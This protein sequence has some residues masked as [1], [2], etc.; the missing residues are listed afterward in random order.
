MPIWPPSAWFS[1]QSASAPVGAGPRLSSDR[2]IAASAAPGASKGFL[3]KLRQTF[4]WPGPT[5]AA[6]MPV[7]ED[8]QVERVHAGPAGIVMPAFLPF[9]ANNQT[10]ETAGMRRAY[11]LMIAVPE[12]KAAL[13]AKVLSAGS[14][15]L[16][17]MP[18]DKK[19]KRDHD[20]AEFVKWDLTRRVKGGF[21]G[22]AWS[23]LAHG[24]IDGYSVSEK[25]WG[26]EESGKHRGRWPL[27]GL[28]PKD[29]GNDVV[30]ELDSFNNI[31][32][33]MGLRYNAGLV[34][35]PADFVIFRHMPLYD[36]PTGMSDLRATYQTYWLLDT[37]WKIRGI[38]SE[39]RAVPFIWGTYQ[40]P[41]QQPTLDA[42]LKAIKSQNWASVPEGVLLQV[43]DIAGSADA[44][45]K[46]I[47]DDLAER[48]FLGIRGATLQSLTGGAQEQRGDS[49]VQERTSNDFDTAVVQALESVLNDADCGLVKDIVDLNFCVGEYPS[50]TLGG[51]D[52]G[53]IDRKAK[54]FQAAH[55]LGLDLSK[56]EIYDSLALTPPATPEDTLP[57]QSAGGTPGPGGP[58]APPGPGG[59][60]G[61]EAPLFGDDQPE[62][63]G[64]EEEPAPFD[65]DHWHEARDLDEQA[66]RFAEHDVTGESR[67]EAGKW[68]S[69]GSGSAK[70]NRG[71]AGEGMGRAGAA[72]KH[73]DRRLNRLHR[74]LRD[75]DVSPDEA[76][77]QAS[78]L[79]AGATGRIIRA[80]SHEWVSVRDGVFSDY[81]ED[82]PV[83]GALLANRREMLR[84]DLEIVRDAV[85]ERGSQVAD[86]APREDRDIARGG[87]DAALARIHDTLAAIPDYVAN[88]Y[89][90]TARAESVGE[91]YR[92]GKKLA[93]RL[94]DGRELT[95]ADQINLKSMQDTSRF[96][97][98]VITGSRVELH[99]PIMDSEGSY[100]TVNPDG[101]RQLTD[102]ETHEPTSPDKLKA[103]GSAAKHGE[104]A[105]PLA[106][107]FADLERFA[108]PRGVDK[109]F[110][111]PSGR[112]F[113]VK[114]RDGKK[115]TIPAR[116]P[117]APAKA[118]P[119]PRG[120]KPDAAAGG[121]VAP[122]AKSKPPKAATP[123]ADEAH[124]KI[125]AHVQA[126]SMSPDDVTALGAHIATMGQP[127]INAL[128]KRLGV[129]QGGKKD[130]QAKGIAEQVL[131]RLGSPASG[132][133]TPEQSAA[134]PSVSQGKIDR[135]LALA[136]R[137]RDLHT[138]AGQ[139]NGPPVEQLKQQTAEALQG[140]QKTA[141][142]QVATAIG[143]TPK[144]GLNAA[145]IAQAII[146]HVA[147][148]RGSLPRPTQPAQPL[149]EAATRPR[150]AGVSGQPSAVALP[151]P[152][153]QGGAGTSGKGFAG[154]EVQARQEDIQR[155]K[156]RLGQSGQK[157][158]GAR[159]PAVKA[160]PPPTPA[161]QPAPA[162]PAAAPPPA[163][164]KMPA[165]ALRE[166]AKKHG[167]EPG[168]MG[169]ADLLKAIKK[170][171]GGQP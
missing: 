22:L 119:K 142:L 139:A 127:E 68:T 88:N 47:T 12:I 115:R 169:R 90:A 75:G 111:G 95:E 136:N 48:V 112:W 118:A 32:G 19:N 61:E 79:T 81:G 130:L 21:P 42:V 144:A 148:K 14:L 165:A 124:D 132:G 89:D 60:P 59:A 143:A 170:A 105:L 28:K 27:V 73:L 26:H 17:V 157:L 30:L 167:I 96:A 25:V 107:P 6:R 106:N 164:E 147:A 56:E 49:E 97:T 161:A 38:A 104:G 84:D 138:Q 18:A 20:V 23:I 4:G 53:E 135:L 145:G 1:S 158:P 149:P 154:P 52:S 123:T 15:E 76:R 66:Q 67:D 11:R 35:S 151:R 126:G 7:G 160:T 116:D 137:V 156:N 29:T 134:K 85:E 103:K 10:A 13:F 39:K 8:V 117:N 153:Q 109:P 55:E 171:Q 44:I 93:K 131:A 83:A 3:A 99:T 33:V 129:V 50:V 146:G 72:T 168:A 91:A 152:G 100:Q 16:R 128:K 62:G 86:E 121:P 24:L 36:S 43:L 45:F 133:G 77:D 87:I 92:V 101:S 114:E 122:A 155:Q 125:K 5:L 80:V 98:L 58:D 54:L 113:V 94:G 141:L 70:S 63:T 51:V 163:L 159:K 74:Q 82:D 71:N 41:A 57:G 31:V 102:A 40:N 65:E 120:Q 110:Q 2:S 162:A 69:G 140:V 37:A 9:V 46:Q 166:L 150:I 34:F 108:E 78:D 64:G